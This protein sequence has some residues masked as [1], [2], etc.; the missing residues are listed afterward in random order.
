ML[1]LMGGNIH[2]GSGFAAKI[3]TNCTA[4]CDKNSQ[5]PADEQQQFVSKANNEIHNTGKENN[6][7]YRT[8]TVVRLLPSNALFKELHTRH[9]LKNK[10]V[11]RKAVS[12][13]FLSQKLREG[14]Y[15]YGLCC[16]RT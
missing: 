16:M 9:I 14:Y 5:T 12:S 2:Q 13:V 10:F 8:L 6:F 1:L 4:E 7:S 11:V 3:T 15:I